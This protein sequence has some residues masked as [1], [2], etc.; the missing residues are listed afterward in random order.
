MYTRGL[1]FEHTNI[2]VIYFAHTCT[3]S[4]YIHGTGIYSVHT[5]YLKIQTSM[6]KLFTKSKKCIITGI[7]PKTLCIIVYC[8]LH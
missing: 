8:V 3:Y 5:W 2:Y 7:E 1:Y 4:A 6:Y